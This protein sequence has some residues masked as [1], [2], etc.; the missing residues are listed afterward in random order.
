MKKKIVILTG[1]PRKS[2]NTAMLAEALTKALEAGQNEVVRFDTAFMNIG[3]CRACGGCYSR[4]KPCVFDG[5]DFN[6]IASEIESADGL[7]LVTPVFWYSFPSH[8]KA[9]IDRFYAFWGGKHLFTGKKCALVA[10]CADKPIETF[11]G[12]VYSYRQSIALLQGENA[13]EV[14]LPGL[15][16]AGAVQSTDGLKKMRLLAQRFE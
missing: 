5:D 12:M 4:G 3:G 10:C 9:A 13:G 14:L 15:G 7:V 1:S 6:R 2:G 16:A 11:D 8:I